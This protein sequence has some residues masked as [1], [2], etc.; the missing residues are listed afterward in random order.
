MIE[1]SAQSIAMAEELARRVGSQGGAALIV[2]YGQDGH[3][4]STLQ[5]IKGHT[6]VNLFSQPGEADLSCRVDFSA[7]R[8]A[9]SQNP[10]LD[11]AV[12]FLQKYKGRP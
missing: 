2:D 1:V 4:D 7:L 9:R 12:F 8:C 11:P 6:F 5:A 10:I 3:M